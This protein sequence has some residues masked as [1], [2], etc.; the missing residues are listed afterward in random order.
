MVTLNIIRYLGLILVQ[1]LVIN[2]ITLNELI[3]P[4]LYPIFILLLPFNTPKWV[5]ILIGFVLG[6][7]VDLFSNSMGVH[8]AAC[9]LMAYLR[10]Y[11]INML[12]PTGGYEVEDIPSVSSLGLT[13]FLPY[14]AILIFIHHIALMLIIFASLSYPLF[15]VSKILLST[16]ASIVLIILYEYIFYPKR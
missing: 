12:T 5:L 13:W 1:V 9:T 10:P 3:N 7:S 11:V 2:Y 4:Y 6:L 8:A 15:L 16:V 14:A